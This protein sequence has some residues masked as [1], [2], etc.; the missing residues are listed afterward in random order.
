MREG[1]S[2]F[3]LILLLLMFMSS[4]HQKTIKSERKPNFIVIVLDDLDFDEVNFYY[5]DTFPCYYGALKNGIESARMSAVP[6]AKFYMPNIDKLASKSA[7]FTRFYA[8]SSVCTPVR[9]ALLTGK[10]A[11]QSPFIARGTPRNQPAFLRW[12]SFIS[13]QEQTIIQPLHDRGYI[14]AIIG[15]WHNG[16]NGKGI[17]I[18]QSKDDLKDPVK[19]KII[20]QDYN[21]LIKF[22]TDSLRFDYADRIFYDNPFILNLEWITEGVR[23]FIDKYRNR[24]FF[25]YLPLPFPHSQYYDYKDYDP[26]AT[27][28][29]FLNKPPDAG[30]TLKNA[31]FKNK[32]HFG[33]KNFSMATWIDD[34][35]G[36][37]FRQLEKYGLDQNTMIVFTSDQQTR[38]KYTCYETCRIPTFIYYPKLIKKTQYIDKLCKITDLLPTIFEIIDGKNADHILNDGRSLVPLFQPDEKQS[39]KWRDDIFLEISYCKGVV[40]GRYK[41]IAA[42]PPDYVYNLMKQDSLDAVRENRRRKISWDGQNWNWKGVVYDLDRDFPFYFDKDQLYDLQNDVFEQKNLAYLPEYQSILLEMKDRLRKHLVN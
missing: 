7:I 26:L 24:P 1:I 32:I 25:L 39:F 2:L 22:L 14:T 42:R 11:W 21:Y 19:S 28:A 35:I 4:C 10:N 12:N 33:N 40:T 20:K 16:A 41:Y 23:I 38:G 6:K 17:M 34:F 27:P 36:V 5:S 3:W 9:Y 15:K 29:G 8:N 37:I 30:H 18:P 31:R 13:P